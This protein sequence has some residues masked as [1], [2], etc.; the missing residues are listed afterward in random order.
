MGVYD[1]KNNYNPNIKC[2]I[3]E[4]SKELLHEY[5]NYDPNYITEEIFIL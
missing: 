4:L 3:Y 2:S 5:Y 1:L